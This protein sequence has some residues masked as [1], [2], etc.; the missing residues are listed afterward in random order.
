MQYVAKYTYIHT[1]IYICLQEEREWAELLQKVDA[2]DLDAN[3]PEIPKQQSSS[4]AVMDELAGDEIQGLQQLHESIQKQVSTQVEGVSLIVGNIEDL[5]EKA[6][7]KT[8]DAQKVL[9]AE[10]YKEYPHVNS[11]ARLIKAIIRPEES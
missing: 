7:K 6:N 1:Y 4:G 3:V 10:R 5:I 11:P 2:L 8:L 9:H